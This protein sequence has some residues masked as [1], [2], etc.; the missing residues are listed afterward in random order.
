MRTL[1]NGATALDARSIQ[2][3][4]WTFPAVTETLPSSGHASWWGTFQRGDHLVVQLASSE[5]PLEVRVLDRRFRFLTGAITGPDGATLD[6]E[7]PRDGTY[8]L[9]F[10]GLAAQRA[11]FTV[12]IRLPLPR[13]HRPP[14]ARRETGMAG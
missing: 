10:D 4:T 5:R 11:D 13:A 7:I 2:H 3:R 14:H 6:F 9:R 8:H 1:T 12:E